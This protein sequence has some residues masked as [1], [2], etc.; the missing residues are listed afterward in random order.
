MSGR[1]SA[2]TLP[3]PQGGN[4]MAK[5][6]RIEVSSGD[7]AF[8]NAEQVRYILQYSAEKNT[9]TICFSGDAHLIVQTMGAD[10]LARTLMS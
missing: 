3:F 7:V 1:L 2:A 4:A 9:C 10:E 5:L 8:I 6:K